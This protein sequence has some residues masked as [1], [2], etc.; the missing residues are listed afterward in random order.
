MLHFNEAKKILNGLFGNTGGNI[1]FG[2]GIYVGLLTKLP[3][4]DEENGW[5]GFE[6]PSITTGYKRINID[7]NSYITGEKFIAHAITAAEAVTIDGCEAFP[8]YVENQ[9]A[10]MFEEAMPGY[11]VDS[12]GNPDT[13]KPKNWVIVGFGLFRSKKNSDND[14]TLPFL[15]GSITGEAEEGGEAPTEV[16]IANEEVPI[17]R[18]G[19]F[20]ISLV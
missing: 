18:Q 19:G 7:G 2:N 11:E 5:Q 13:E 6:E 4:Y 3:E 1:S 9:A 16:V 17:I 10:I 14:T 8:S 20:K 12:E 15:W